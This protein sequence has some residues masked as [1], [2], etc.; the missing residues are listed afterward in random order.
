MALFQ[1]Q[2]VKLRKNSIKPSLSLLVE[3]NDH[4]VNYK[5][6]K[7]KKGESI[8]TIAEKFNLPEELLLELNNLRG[9]QLNPGE[10]IDIYVSY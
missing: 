2:R 1:F 8:I 5:Q 9:Y 4:A 10:V 6:Y 3:L 7:V